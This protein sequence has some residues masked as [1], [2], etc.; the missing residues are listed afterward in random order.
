MKL[1]NIMKELNLLDW[2]SLLIGWNFGWVTRR[3]VIDYAVTWLTEHPDEM[4]ENVALIAGGE[5]YPDNELREM[6]AKYLAHSSDFNFSSDTSLIMD[7]W[8]LAHLIK[9]AREDIDD[10]DKLDQ[11]EAVYAVFN[12]PEDMV[13]CSRYYLNED[14]RTKGWAVGDQ[15][16][17]PLSAM[18]MVVE[19]LKKKLNVD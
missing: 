7:K 19:R 8:R 4:D 6:V 12:Y 5:S 3:E 13:A 14:E 10:E 17:G 1:I 11:L 15:S 18:N 2:Q 16:A 9:I